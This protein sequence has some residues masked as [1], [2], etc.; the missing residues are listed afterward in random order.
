MVLRRIIT[1]LSKSSNLFLLWDFAER[2]E[3]TKED[4]SQFYGAPSF[5]LFYHVFYVI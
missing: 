3:K 4:A 5:A 2:L 1:P